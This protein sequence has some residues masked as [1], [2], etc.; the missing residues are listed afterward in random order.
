M[1]EKSESDQ[2][3]KAWMV[4]RII[5]G[6]LVGSLVIYLLVCKLIEDQLKP[7]VDFPFVTMKYALF[8]V[9]IMTFFITSF[10]RKAI[11]KSSA[12]SAT[13]AIV[14]GPSSQIQNPAEGKYTTPLSWPWPSPKASVFTAWCFLS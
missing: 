7:A 3:D 1:L 10:V 8:G 2:L 9:S 11:L 13:S 14:R 4:I 5:W 12:G 6:A